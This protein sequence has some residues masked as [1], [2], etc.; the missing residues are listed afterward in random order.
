MLPGGKHITLS[1]RR[2]QEIETLKEAIILCNPPYGHRLST[3]T[4]TASLLQKFGTFLKE[5]CQGT[6]TYIYVGK[7]ALPKQIPLW[8]SW[9]KPLDNGGLH[10]Y[11]AKYKIR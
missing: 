6:V 2:F 7:E 8:P 11:L 10:E 4:R 1:P 9:K 5:R 3:P